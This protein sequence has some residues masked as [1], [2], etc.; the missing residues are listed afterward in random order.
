M[1]GV[2]FGRN[3]WK[4]ECVAELKI[5]GRMRVKEEEGERTK[6]WQLKRYPQPNTNNAKHAFLI[7]KTIIHFDLCNI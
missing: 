3:G 2:G 4:R 1:S 6:S 5:T 7:G